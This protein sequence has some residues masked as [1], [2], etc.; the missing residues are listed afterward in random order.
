[1]T[2]IYCIP[3]GQNPVRDVNNLLMIEKNGKPHK[4]QGEKGMTVTFE[5]PAVFVSD[6]DVSRKFYTEALGQEVQADFGENVVFKGGFSIWQA[7][8]AIDVIYRG[9]R[10]LPAR[11]GCDNMELYFECADLEK[12]LAAVQNSHGELIRPIEEAPWGQRGFRVHDPDGHIVEIGEPLSALVERL[13]SQGLSI[14]EVSQRT[15]I[16]PDHVRA[17]SVR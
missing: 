1:M 15:S 2:G 16:P 6:I 11:L 3:F 10:T 14:D 7:G 8:H 12:A 17:L 13:L 4:K 9:K 5:G